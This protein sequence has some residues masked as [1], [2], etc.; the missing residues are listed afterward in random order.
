VLTDSREV[1]LRVQIDPG[2]AALEFLS[3]TL[4][5]LEDYGFTDNIYQPSTQKWDLSRQ[6]MTLR[7]WHS[8]NDEGSRA[9]LK[10]A[11]KSYR[12]N[13][14]YQV[15]GFKLP[16]ESLAIG[17]EV[18]SSW[19]FRQLFSFQRKGYAF[20]DPIFKVAIYLENIE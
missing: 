6:Y 2:D 8:G 11:M 14:K 4:G 9:T 12:G 3:Q 13:V 10:F 5:P 19:S 18:L 15:F 20:E 16:V 1:E 7:E 17:Q